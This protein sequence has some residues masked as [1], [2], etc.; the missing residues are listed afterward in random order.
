MNNMIVVLI[1]KVRLIECFC[2]IN[3]SWI[4][5]IIW[6]ARIKRKKLI[7]N[8]ARI[9]LMRIKICHWSTISQ[10]RSR[11]IPVPIKRVEGMN[12]NQARIEQYGKRPINS[13][14]FRKDIPA[15]Q[16]DKGQWN[17]NAS[18]FHHSLF[19][20][21]SLLFLLICPIKQVSISM[22]EF[23][24]KQPISN[25]NSN[26]EVAIWKKRTFNSRGQKT[27]YTNQKSN[28]R[29][30][31]F[32]EAIFFRNLRHMLNLHLTFNNTMKCLTKLYE[33]GKF[34]EK[35]L[36]MWLFCQ[37]NLRGVTP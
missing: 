13:V 36:Y 11:Q 34:N 17:C 9:K 10:W 35:Y 4:V 18:I 7:R 14:F 32:P 6:I 30:W 12:N 22:P 33:T 21:T 8:L 23:F 20:R 15:S 29:I 27:P 25:Q 19:V 28:K 31:N 1:K 16:Q 2:M 37:S 24:N 26:Q 3:W 5:W